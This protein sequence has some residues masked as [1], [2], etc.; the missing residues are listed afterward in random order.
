M[1]G[2]LQLCVNIKKARCDGFGCKNKRIN[3]VLNRVM[4]IKIVC[5]LWQFGFELL[6]VVLPF[7]C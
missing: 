4:L 2:G 7:C 5:A 3:L 6:G 1:I